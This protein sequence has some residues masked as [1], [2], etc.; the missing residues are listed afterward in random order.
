MQM[1]PGKYNYMSECPVCQDTDHKVNFVV[2]IRKT[3]DTKQGM[4]A[5]ISDIQTP[6]CIHSERIE[7]CTRLLGVI[8]DA[9]VKGT[10]RM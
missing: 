1:V 6:N 9:F 3:D 8:F 5:T 10:A 4:S 7:N 2:T